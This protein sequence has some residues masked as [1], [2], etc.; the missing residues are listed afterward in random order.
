MSQAN[1]HGSPPTADAQ[2]LDHRRAALEEFCRVN[3]WPQRQKE[4]VRRLDRDGERFLRFFPEPRRASSTSA[5]SSRWRSR[6]RPTQTAADGL[7]FGIHFARQRRAGH[8]DAGELFLVNIGTLGESIGLRENGAGRRNAAS[9]GQRRHDLA[10]R[11]AHLVRLARPSERCRADA[12]GHG[13]DR[14][15]PGPDRHDPPAHQRHARDQNAV[16]TW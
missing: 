2:R 4:T 12:E 7:F 10:P 8:R 11:P 13:Q 1:R 16:E 9:Q 15:V 3:Q 6:T 5:S 14:R